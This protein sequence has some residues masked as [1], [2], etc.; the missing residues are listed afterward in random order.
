MNTTRNQLGSFSKNPSARTARPALRVVQYLDHA[1]DGGRVV[2][3]NRRKRLLA[4]Q[5]AEAE[6]DCNVLPRRSPRRHPIRGVPECLRR[7]R[8]RPHAANFYTSPSSP[9]RRRTLRRRARAQ[10]TAPTAKRFIVI[11]PLASHSANF[12]RVYS[13]RRAQSEQRGERNSFVK[14]SAPP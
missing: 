13:I 10:Q 8:A 4:A 7:R 6:R 11:P 14:S 2:F 9:P 1:S 5:A 3:V 12:F